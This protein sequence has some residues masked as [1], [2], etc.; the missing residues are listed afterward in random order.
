MGQSVVGSDATLDWVSVLGCNTIFTWV[1]V[2]TQICTFQAA[3]FQYFEISRASDAREREGHQHDKESG[4][5]SGKGFKLC[6]LCELCHKHV[7][8]TQ[9]ATL[10]KC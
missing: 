8:S 2:F 1:K 7:S 10:N 5:E 4:L 9:N 6:V 3:K